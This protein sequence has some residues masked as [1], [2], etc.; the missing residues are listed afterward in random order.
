MSIIFETIHSRRSREF[1]FLCFLQAF[2]LLFLATFVVLIVAAHAVPETSR[3]VTGR[4]AAENVFSAKKA[5][6]SSKPQA[7]EFKHFCQEVFQVSRQ[8]M[9]L[10][11]R[12]EIP[13]AALAIFRDKNHLLYRYLRVDSNAYEM[14]GEAQDMLVNRIA[15]Y[16]HAECEVSAGQIAGIAGFDAIDWLFEPSIRPT[17]RS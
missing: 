3:E 1:P 15:A 2:A 7:A 9:F 5:C 14:F 4:D 11:A 16:S 8:G 13:N 17:C 6:M 12:T 10:K